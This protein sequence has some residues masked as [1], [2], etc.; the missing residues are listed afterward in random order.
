MRV[1]CRFIKRNNSLNCFPLAPWTDISL[2]LEKTEVRQRYYLTEKKNRSHWMPKRL[3]L[4]SPQ[5]KHTCAIQQQQRKTII[6]V[7]PS[8]EII[9]KKTIAN[10]SNTS[11]WFGI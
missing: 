11:L 3:L 4:T 5:H 2:L 6:H 8:D 7:F 10:V 9:R 1:N